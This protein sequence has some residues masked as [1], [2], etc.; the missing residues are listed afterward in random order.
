MTGPELVTVA[1]LKAARYELRG[2][3]NCGRAGHLYQYE[4]RDFPRLWIVKRSTRQDGIVV[5]FLVDDIEVAD[6]AAAASALNN[7][8]P[9]PP[10]PSP[11]LVLL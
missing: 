6:L 8:P 5:G 4:C 10:E 1:R 3:V 9:S 7:P 2:H 11:Q